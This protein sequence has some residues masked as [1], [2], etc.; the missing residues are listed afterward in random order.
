MAKKVA[1][2]GAGAS[3]IC[4]IKCCLDEGLEPTCFERSND[5]G[6]LWRFKEKPDLK[7]ASIYKTLIINTSKEMMCFSDFPIPDDFP[8]YMHHSKIWK[9]FKMYVDHFGLMKYIQVETSVCSVKK[10]PDFATSGQWDVTTKTSN[11][12]EKT[13]VF[14]AV[15]VCTGHHCDP[16]LPLDSFP[17]IEKFKGRYLHSR[18]YKSP[19]E[20]EGKRVIVIGIGNSGGDLSV[21]VSRTASQ[22]F[23]STRRGAWIVNRVATNGY[24]VDMVRTCRAVYALRYI[25]PYSVQCSW[26]ESQLNQ[27][28]NHK[29]YSLQP[30]HRVLSQHPTVNDDL[31]NRII[32]GTVIVK[33]NVKEFTETAAVFEDGTVEENIDVVIFATGYRFSYPFLE[34]SIIEVRNNIT[35]LY[36]Y[37]FPPRLEQPTLA[38]IG[39]VQPLGAIMPVSEIQ[40]RWAARVFKGLAKLPSAGAM[41]ADIIKKKE[42]LDRRYV[43]TQRHTIQIDYIDYMDE[44]AEI[45]GVK[46]NMLKL[47]LRNPV[48]A[49][50]V[51]FGPCTPYQFRLTG[52]GKW[53]GAEKAIMTQWDRVVKPTMTRPV[54]ARQSSFPVL[55]VL[56]VLILVV[57]F[58]LFNLLPLY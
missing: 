22:V 41:M 24:P 1:I 16:N 23:L 6:G 45:L 37:V 21:E 36:K 44:I 42:D 11:G 3:G 34:D 43:K 40:S 18:E 19:V 53:G 55:L 10:R 13:A 9:Y 51:F 54:K 50:K 20:F 49:W 2:I 48:L 29:N 32:S 31:P 7:T 46:T 8:N 52:P 14:D 58:F 30:E 17:G 15:L 12:E 47:L 38:V 25:L 33:P 35:D 28:F 27:R 4:A 39:L 56:S 5:F 26:M 57:A